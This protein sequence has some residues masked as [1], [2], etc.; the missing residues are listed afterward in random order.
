MIKFNSMRR[1]LFGKV[2]SGVGLLTGG[3]S[4]IFVGSATAQIYL[5]TFVLIPGA[6]CGSWCWRRVADL[7]E[8]Q[9]HKV[10]TPTLTGLGDRSHLLS[11]NIDM[12]T[13]ITDIVNLFRWE[14]LEDVCLVAHSYGGA[15]GSGALEQ[16]ADRVS[17]IVWLDAFKLEN[18]QAVLD[19]T[20]DA[21]R[22][23]VLDAAEKDE[24]S[25]PP[26][27]AS[28]IFVNEKDQTFVDSKLT[29][30]P[31]ETYKQKIRLSG[32]IETVARKT[33]IRIQKYPIPAFDKALAEAKAK[34]W[35][36]FELPDS[37]HMAM[38]DA[39]ERLTDLLLHAA[40]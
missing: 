30:H 35:R 23:K 16:I 32:A 27:K 14:S 4:G 13:H 2:A 38:L 1:S 29:P 31:I 36:T 20:S 25:F 7:L 15:P 8:W 21:V 6:F 24:F 34:S 17:S 12:D 5:K 33:Y 10:F 40:Y 3:Q 26:A 18:G 22:K 28:V 39:P 11:K 37:G 9:G 19:V